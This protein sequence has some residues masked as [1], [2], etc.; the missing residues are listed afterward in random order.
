MVREQFH[1]ARAIKEHVV[2]PQ[3]FQPILQPLPI[4]FELLEGVQDPSIGAQL[5][6][7][8][9]FIQSD[10]V[11]DVEG[12]RVRGVFVG[13]IKIDNGTFAADG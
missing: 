11:A 5:L 12:A 8:H 7:R 10:E 2:F 9:D 3:L 1:L 6:V 4:V 13:G